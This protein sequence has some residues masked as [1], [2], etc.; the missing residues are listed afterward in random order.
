MGEH[1]QRGECRKQQIL[2]PLQKAP[3][4]TSTVLLLQDK[5]SDYS[6]S[7]LLRLLF[8]INPSFIPSSSPESLIPVISCL[9]TVEH[10]FPAGLKGCCLLL[11]LPTHPQRFL[12]CLRCTALLCLSA[13]GV[14]NSSAVLQ[15]C[16]GFPIPPTPVPK[17]TK[18]QL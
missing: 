18:E 3:L 8:K 17:V 13:R 6:C 14:H 11:L 15:A 16:G 2:K 10:V 1:I 12:T 7:A 5:L 4:V 9:P